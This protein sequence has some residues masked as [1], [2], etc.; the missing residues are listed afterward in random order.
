VDS[1]SLA[2]LLCPCLH[3]FQQPHLLAVDEGLIRHQGAVKSALLVVAP[4]LGGDGVC[5]CHCHRVT[6]TTQAV[7]EGILPINPHPHLQ[8][9]VVV[10]QGR[11]LLHGVPLLLTPGL[12]LHH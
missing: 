5:L 1:G 10:S 4:D 2:L 6:P 3:S 11:G 7:D 8:A 12:R 9:A